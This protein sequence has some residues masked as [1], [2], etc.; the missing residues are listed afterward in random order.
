MHRQQ[1]GSS[2]L[3]TFAL[4]YEHT[5]IYFPFGTADLEHRVFP[6]ILFWTFLSRR[7]RT[8]TCQ[9]D[10]HTTQ[11][12]LHTENLLI[13]V[14]QLRLG[15]ENLHG[16]GVGVCVGHTHEVWKQQQTTAKCSFGYSTGRRATLIWR[17]YYKYN[18]L[19]NYQQRR[20]T[21]TAALKLSRCYLTFYT[22]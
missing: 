15:E 8:L 4:L 20:K 19:V 10:L 13:T 17:L 14:W 12:E 5:G 9:T 16:G 3:L 18:C 11:R 21:F 1:G 6:M 22:R 2:L 7:W